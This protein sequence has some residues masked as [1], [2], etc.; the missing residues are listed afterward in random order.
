MGENAASKVLRF[1]GL[2]VQRLNGSIV[3]WLIGVTV[4]VFR[5]TPHVLKHLA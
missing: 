2:N 4:V 1:N 5:D 3:Y